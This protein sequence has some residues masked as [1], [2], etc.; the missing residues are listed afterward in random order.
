MEISK[1][2]LTT[3]WV[4]RKKNGIVKGR[5]LRLLF[6]RHEIT[7][8][9]CMDKLLRMLRENKHGRKAISEIIVV[10]S[11]TN[12]ETIEYVRC[13]Y[14]CVIDLTKAYRANMCNTLIF[15]ILHKKGY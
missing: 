3:K 8:S 13:V 14:L 7:L 6:Q 2:E 1:C 5:I 12:R 9:R 4:F 15:E 10:I 11:A